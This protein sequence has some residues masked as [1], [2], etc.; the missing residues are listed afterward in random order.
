[1][2]MTCW[3]TRRRSRCAPLINEPHLYVSERCLQVRWM[4]TPLHGPAAGEHCKDYAD[5]VRYMAQTDL[6]YVTA[7]MKKWREG[8]SY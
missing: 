6:L 2:S 8:G 4:F 1:M 7:Q 5:L 3:I